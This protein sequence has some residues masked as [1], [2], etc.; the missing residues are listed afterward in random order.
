M[1]IVAPR[2]SNIIL[3]VIFDRELNQKAY[4]KCPIYYLDQRLNRTLV[5]HFS[6]VEAQYWARYSPIYRLFLDRP[7]I[8]SATGRR[9]TSRA[10]KHARRNTFP[11]EYKSPGGEGFLFIGYI[12]QSCFRNLFRSMLRPHMQKSAIY[13][14]GLSSRGVRTRTRINACARAKYR[15]NIP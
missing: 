1:S 7:F 12:Q 9:C 11:N 13:D 4:T 14:S 10:R 6:H 8:F 3:E 2:A 15:C 5:E